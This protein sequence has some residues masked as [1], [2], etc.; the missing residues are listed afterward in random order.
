L[1]FIVAKEHQAV[2][3]WSQTYSATS[4][5]RA[6][7]LKCQGKEWYREKFW[8]QC[9]IKVISHERLRYFIGQN[10]NRYVR[11][12]DLEHVVSC[13]LL[14]VPLNTLALIP[15]STRGLIQSL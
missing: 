5:G 9:D 6:K 14:W 7:L 11:N 12:C 3:G 8:W 4:L 10:V 13:L 1:S 2:T 15:K